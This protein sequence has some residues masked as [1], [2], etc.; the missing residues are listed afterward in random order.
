MPYRDNFFWMWEDKGQE[1]I[2]GKQKL[3]TFGL[4]IG[5]IG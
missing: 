5:F 4:L 2:M 1:H 3:Y